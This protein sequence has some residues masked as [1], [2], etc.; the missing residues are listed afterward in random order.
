MMSARDRFRYRPVPLLWMVAAVAVLLLVVPLLAGWDQPVRYGRLLV[1]PVVLVTC[2]YFVR[3]RR[4]AERRLDTLVLGLLVPGP[5]RPSALRDQVPVDSDMLVDSLGRLLGAALIGWFDIDPR[6]RAAV[7][8]PSRQR[9][10][11]IW[12]AVSAPQGAAD[13]S[14]PALGATEKAREHVARPAG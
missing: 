12:E 14:A 5:Q 2:W 1:P 11:D 8:L 7:E 10:P 9:G 13:G 6:S 3:A 4:R